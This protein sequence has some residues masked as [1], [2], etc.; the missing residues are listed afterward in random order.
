MRPKTTVAIVLLFFLNAFSASFATI[1]V[2]SDVELFF[3]EASETSAR[4]SSCGT[5]STLTDLSISMDAS[6]YTQGSS[7]IATYYINCSVNGDYYDLYVSI[8]GP[9]V[10]SYPGWNWTESNAYESFNSTI[11]TLTVGTFCVNASLYA[12]PSG[13]N[14]YLVDTESHCFTVS[15]TSSGGGGSSTYV[16]NGSLAIY[17]VSSNY[18]SGSNVTAFFD[19]TNLDTGVTYGE[20]WHLTDANG[21]A[22]QGYGVNQTWNATWSNTNSTATFGNLSNGTYCIT[23]T[24]YTVYSNG[25]AVIL[26]T[27]TTCF[28]IGS[29]TPTTGCGYDWNLASIVVSPNDYAFIPGEDHNATIYSSCSLFNENMVLRYNVTDTSSGQTLSYGSWQWVPISSSDF[30]YFE[31]LNLAT[32]VYDVQVGLYHYDGAATYTLLD[33]TKYNFTVAQTPTV[34]ET[35]DINLNGLNYSTGQ[36]IVATMNATNLQLWSNYTIIW[37]LLDDNAFTVDSGNMTID[38]FSSNDVTSQLLL[39]AGSNGTY[40]LDAELYDVNW[41]MVAQDDTCFNVGSTTPP[42][43]GGGNNNNSTGAG[44]NPSNP[45]M[46]VVNC[47]NIAWNL[48]TNI[49]I[50][51]CLNNT[52]AFWFEFNQSGS[53][54]W[55]DPVVAVGYDFVVYNGLAMTSVQIPTGYGDDVF[56]LYLYSGNGWYDTNIDINAGVTYTFQSPVERMSIRGIEAYEML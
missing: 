32:G 7:A 34:N 22:V 6:S 48:T 35:L 47:S 28:T 31:N 23:A 18:S 37:S 27:N 36:S 20:M 21:N 39:T 50:N 19:Y 43:N 49:T 12:T 24:L 38:S 40:C 30:H 10:Q 54:V 52:N 55:I 29:T 3:S 56:D 5:N 15:S 8:S 4:N 9:S 2:Q 11:Y 1:P 44:S 25:T 46:P 45:L 14:F 16:P 17:G 41:N 33:D 42:N 51:D 26:D 13:G 53:I